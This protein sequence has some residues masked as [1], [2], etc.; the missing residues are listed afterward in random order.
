MLFAV[1]SPN[2]HCQES[3]VQLIPVDSSVKYTEIGIF[4]VR[5]SAENADVTDRIMCVSSLPHALTVGSVAV[6]FR[7]RTQSKYIYPSLVPPIEYKAIARTD[8]AAF[9]MLVVCVAISDPSL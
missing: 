2:D 9:G 3:T 6:Y 7:T 5:G 1:E 8:P 4:P